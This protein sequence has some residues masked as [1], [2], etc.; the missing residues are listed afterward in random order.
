[1]DFYKL[2]DFFLFPLSVGFSYRCVDGVG[3]KTLPLRGT[4]T[5]IFTEKPLRLLSLLVGM[6]V[7]LVEVTIA[8]HCRMRVVCPT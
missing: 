6:R 8:R 5:L 3:K 7:H 2:F 4:K 1:M